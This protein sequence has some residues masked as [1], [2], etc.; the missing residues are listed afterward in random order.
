MGFQPGILLQVEGAVV[1]AL[2]LFCYRSTGARWWV[3]LL[4]FLWPDLF[5]LGY[6]VSVRAGSAMYNFVHTYALPL[7]LAGAAL[8]QHDARLWSF[9]LIWV[10]HI[11]ANRAL[12]YGLKYPTFFKDTHLQRVD[13]ALPTAASN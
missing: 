12:G 3:F 4:L 9:A 10:A 1:F 7:V 13:Q 6:L 11:G 8:S 2:S 5:M